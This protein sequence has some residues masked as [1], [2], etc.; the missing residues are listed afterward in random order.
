M[1]K[2]S[3][4]NYALNNQV[5]EQVPSNLYHDLQI[6]KDLTWKEYINNVTKKTKKKKKKKANST[7]GFLR[8]NIQ[9]CPRECRKTAHIALVRSVIEYGAII[10]YPCTKQEITKLESIQRRGA[11]SPR[12]TNLVTLNDTIE[13]PV[14]SFCL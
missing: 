14:A 6:S 12:I 11:R 8:R 9:H 3:H 10:W 1:K 7:A 13:T 5:S 2:K 4:R